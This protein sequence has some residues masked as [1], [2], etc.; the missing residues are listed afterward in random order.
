[1]L[2]GRNGNISELAIKWLHGESEAAERVAD[3]LQVSG[4][5]LAD[6]AAHAIP[7][8]AVELERIDLQVERHDSQRDSLLHR[9][10]RRGNVKA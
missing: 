10:E 5:S 3:T 9:I 4:F 6:I 7:V 8:T 2:S 1:L